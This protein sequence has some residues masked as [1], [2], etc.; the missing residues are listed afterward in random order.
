[1][2]L[3]E[4]IFKLVNTLAGALVVLGDSNRLLSFFH[5]LLLL[6]LDLVVE[7]FLTMVKGVEVSLHLLVV[8]NSL[9]NQDGVFLELLL[10]L[11][12]LIHT[13]LDAR[14]KL[15]TFL[16][17]S[18]CVVLSLRT[19]AVLKSVGLCGQGR[20]TLVNIYCLRPHAIELLLERTQLVILI[21]LR[22][23]SFLKLE[24]LIGQS[25]FIKVR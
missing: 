6:L 16:L 8:G 21:R 3:L 13:L 17:L 20:E 12:N 22:L 1:M 11:F 25:L 23:L 7:V 15:L 24:C 10:Q 9:G 18:L 14:L 4:L 5:V 19:L 2:E